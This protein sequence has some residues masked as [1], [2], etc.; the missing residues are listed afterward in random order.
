MNTPSSVLIQRLQK[1]QQLYTTGF[2]FGTAKNAFYWIIQFVYILLA[3]ASLFMMF[4][5][6]MNPF[7][8]D[9]VID[10]SNSIH[11]ELENEDV[12][13]LM[14]FIKFIF[15]CAFV[16]FVIAAV[17]CSKVRKRNNRLIAIE[18]ELDE[19]IEDLQK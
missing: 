10:E 18:K 16:A 9:T 7:Q 11:A 13:L 8:T 6:P 17:I 4:L 19:I 3:L 14:I 5:I 1:I 12:Q 2:I 15:F